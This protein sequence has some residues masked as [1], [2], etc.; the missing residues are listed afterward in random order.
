MSPT[1]SVVTIVLGA[2]LLFAGFQAN[3]GLVIGLGALLVAVAVVSGL[4]AGGANQQS[5]P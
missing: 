5:S 4:A 3:L 2:A 1:V